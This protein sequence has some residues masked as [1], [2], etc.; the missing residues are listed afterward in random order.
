M[1]KGGRPGN[2]AAPVHLT[3]GYSPGPLATTQ[4]HPLPVKSVC[5]PRQPRAWQGVAAR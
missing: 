3:S 2:R 1:V 5:H 4:P